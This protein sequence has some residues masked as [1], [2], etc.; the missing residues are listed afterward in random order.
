M[1]KGRRKN[2]DIRALCQTH[3]TSSKRAI[4]LFINISLILH[5]RV[6]ETRTRINILCIIINL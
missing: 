6:I 2:R 1:N 4:N 5:W 3:T